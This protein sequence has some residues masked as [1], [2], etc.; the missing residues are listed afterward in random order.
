MSKKGNKDEVVLNVVEA[1]QHPDHSEECMKIDVIEPLVEEAFEVEKLEE[2]LETILEDTLL[3]L[4][5]LA[6]QREMLSIPSVEEGPPKIELK[7]LPPSLKYAFVGD[8]NTYPMV[9]SSSL[10]QHEEEALIQV[11]KSHKTTLG[12]T[13]SD[14]KGINPTKCMHKRISPTSCATTEATEPNYERGSPEG[15]YKALRSWNHISYLRQSMGKPVQVVPKKGGMTVIHNE[16]NELIPTRTVTGWRMCIDYKR[17]NNATRKDHFP[18]S[19][20]DQMLERLSGHAF[21]YFLDGYSGYKQ[22]VVDSQDQE[23]AA[24]T[25]PYRVFTYMRMPFGLSKLVSAPIIAAPNWNLPFKLMCDASDYAIGAVLRKRQ[26]KL[27]HVIY[28]A[29]RVL[30]NAQKNYTTTENELLEVIYAIDKF[31]SYLIGSKVFD[32]EIRDRKGSENQVADH[33][34]RIE[35]EEG[36]PPPTATVTETF[37]DEYL[38][39]IQKTPWFAD[40]ANYKAMRF[41][42][43]EYTKQ[44]VRKLL[45]DAKYYLWDEPYLFKRCSDGMIRRCVSEEEAQ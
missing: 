37:S 31:R 44:Q 20:I 9:I 43:K 16:K 36:T 30:N 25:C 29:S 28:Y 40:I 10:M 21:Y 33:L 45:H 19:F 3:E 4:D 22:I 23:K 2:E 8:G 39:V 35:L 17:H 32:I 24:F 5:E 18:I 6:P 12:W 15:S 38:F 41:I 14:L 13:I 11:L 27:I 26:D 1:M 42:P 7:S 34:S